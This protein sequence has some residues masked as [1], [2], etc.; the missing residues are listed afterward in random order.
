M[1]FSIARIAAFSYPI[2]PLFLKAVALI[3]KLEHGLKRRES[4]NFLYPSTKATRPYWDME[5][6]DLLIFGKET[7]GL[8]D[9]FRERFPEDFYTIPMFHPKVR[10]LNL[11]NAVC[12]VLYH[13]IT[14]GS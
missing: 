14:L 3:P 13:Q 2:K 8:P 5:P 1:K 4:L 11:A 10:S 6:V 7:V 9:S 12:I